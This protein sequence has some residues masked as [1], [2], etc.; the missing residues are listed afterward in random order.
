MDE[1][2][3]TFPTLLH[4]SRL[5]IYFLFINIEKNQLFFKIFFKKNRMHW[6]E[7]N[8]KYQFATDFSFYLY[9]SLIIIPTTLAIIKMTKT[10]NLTFF[11]FLIRMS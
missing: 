7:M 8:N 2:R 3:K 5:F 1:K 10:L 11:I 9:K 6:T 4:R